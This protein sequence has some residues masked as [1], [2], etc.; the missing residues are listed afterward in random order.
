[1]SIVQT[2]LSSSH[3]TVMTQ[4]CS[5]PRVNCG[6]GEGEPAR[7]LLTRR[8]AF[9]IQVGNRTCLARPGQAV[10]LGR[11]V[12]YRVSHPDH[13]GCACCT[14]VWLEDAWLDGLGLAGAHAPACLDIQ[15]DL[16]LQQAHVE[17]LLGM[18]GGPDALEAEEALLAVLDGL[19][20]GGEPPRASNRG[21]ARQVR[22]AQEAIV[23]SPGE[24]LGVDELARVAGCSPFHL[25]RIF[26]QGT[27]QSLRQFRV[28]H[29][30]GTALGRLGEGE[31]DLAALACDVGFSSHSHMT[32][33]FRQALGVSPSDLRDTLRA[34]DL[35]R[36]HARLTAGRDARLH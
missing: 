17:M 19:M 23:A 2:V 6:H 25:C 21:A 11:D 14:D 3:F 18:R 33:A 20:H 13:R 7:F 12:E 8:G 22:R 28:Q 4:D 35:K 26:R 32:D 36:L 5:Y 16:H 15:H 24:N 31:E 10:F 29:R 34:S 27:G 9:S 30:L 1:M